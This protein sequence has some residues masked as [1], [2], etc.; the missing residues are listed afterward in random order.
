MLRNR[1][2]LPAE[3]P[4]PHLVRPLQR[5]TATPSKAP[6]ISVL[7]PVRNEERAIS[8]TLRHLLEQDY[9]PDRFEVIVAD[10][11]STDNTRDRVQA[12]QQRYPNLHLVNN[13]GRWSSAGRNAALEVAHGELVVI[14]DGHCDINNSHHLAELADA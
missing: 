7:V 13:P 8:A 1:K 2:D 14:V 9:D 12:L 4:P 6:F 5:K 3:L 11:E 10:G